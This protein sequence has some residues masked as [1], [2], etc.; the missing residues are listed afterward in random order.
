MNE[1]KNR[2]KNN[3]DRIKYLNEKEQEMIKDQE[4]EL[5]IDFDKAIQE[6][7]KKSIIVNFLNK[8]YYL[9]IKMPFNFSTFFLRNCLTKEKGVTL[10]DIPDDKVLEFIKLMFGEVFFKSLEDSKDSGISLSLVFDK[11]VP[12]IL[13]Q[14]GYDTTKDKNIEKKTKMTI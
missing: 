12:P 1:N 14:W 11:L 7:K 8:N 2:F 9:P 13:K 5:F 6:N 10:V 3:E 4:A